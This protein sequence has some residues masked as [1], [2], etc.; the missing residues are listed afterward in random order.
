QE[1]V[2]LTRAGYEGLKRELEELLTE[3][4]AEVNEQLM[5]ANDDT[6]PG[7]EPTFFDAVVAKERLNERI[8]Y[9]KDVLAR[10]EIIEEDADP[11]RVTPGNRVTVWDMVE[12]EQLI[13]DLLSGEEVAHGRHGVSLESP[14]GKALMGHQ[15]GD[16]VEVVI[17]DGRARY[18]IRKI[19]TAF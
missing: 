13:F 3:G 14:V 11:T 6:S 5:D 9:L 1:P 16:V 15:I 4:S 12:K 10:A 8:L 7:E 17:P 2:I 19:E 18:K